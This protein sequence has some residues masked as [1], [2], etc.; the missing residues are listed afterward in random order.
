VYP[1]VLAKGN[2]QEPEVNH[3]PIKSPH[4]LI[5]KKKG[6]F[7]SLGRRKNC[8]FFWVEIT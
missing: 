5:K 1:G 2:R 6:S 4:A 8:P 7:S 3:R